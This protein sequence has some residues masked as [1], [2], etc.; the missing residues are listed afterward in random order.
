MDQKQTILRDIQQEDYQLKKQNEQNEEKDA[1]DQSSRPLRRYLDANL[2]PIL[3]EGIVEILTNFPSDPVDTLAE[4][5]FQNSLKV[6]NP[7]PSTF[8][9]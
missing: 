1:L 2:V 4:F 8:E 3:S 5:L 7:D 9:L 6:P